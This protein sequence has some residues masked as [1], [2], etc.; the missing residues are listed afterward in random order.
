ME[1][2]K[3]A[4]GCVSDDRDRIPLEEVEVFEGLDRGIDEKPGERSIDGKPEEGGVDE[5]PK[6]RRVYRKP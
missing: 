3:E 6:K 1:L 2:E 5:M 4:K